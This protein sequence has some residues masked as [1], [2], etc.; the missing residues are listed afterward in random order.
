MK[1]PTIQVLYLSYSAKLM[2]TSGDFGF[3]LVC[4]F[5]IQILYDDIEFRYRYDC[6]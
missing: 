6:Y 5:L 3:D 1:N 2:G 4:F